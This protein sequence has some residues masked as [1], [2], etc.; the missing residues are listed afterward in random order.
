MASAPVPP[1]ANVSVFDWVPI[2]SYS[3]KIG[4][5]SSNPKTIGVTNKGP[6]LKI[7]KIFY[8]SP[9]FV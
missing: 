7:T 1:I 3:Y 6:N 5:P 4:L 2:V 9:M 8:I